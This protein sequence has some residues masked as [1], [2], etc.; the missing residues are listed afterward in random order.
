MPAGQDTVGSVVST[1]VI[2]EVALPVLP[3]ASVALKVTVLVVPTA[4]SPLTRSLLGVRAPSTLSLAVALASQAWMAA[5]LV[6]VPPVVL[7]STVRGAGADT[8]GAA[9]SGGGPPPSSGTSEPKVMLSKPVWL[10]TPP[11]FTEKAVPE[12]V[13][14]TGA[15][16]EKLP[17]GSPEPQSSCW[18]TMATVPSTVPVPSSPS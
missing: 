13:T 1:T 8:T 2:V 9:M 3:A 14:P 7:H 4:Q 5:L 6:G 17:F 11:K 10:A 15:Q 12:K 16:H 18:E